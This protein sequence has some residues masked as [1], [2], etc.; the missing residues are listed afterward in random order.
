VSV[1]FLLLL[2]LATSNYHS[3][4]LFDNTDNVSTFSETNHRGGR[5]VAEVTGHCPL[6]TALFLTNVSEAGCTVIIVRLIFIVPN[7]I[8]LTLV[9]GLEF[10]GTRRQFQL[11]LLV[12]EVN[13]KINLFVSESRLKNTGTV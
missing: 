8:L 3:R 1:L 7:G 9:Y 5:P 6:S 13:Q 4:R 10:R 2:R 11:G 12:S